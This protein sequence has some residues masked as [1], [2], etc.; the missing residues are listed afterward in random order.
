MDEPGGPDPEWEAYLAWL[1]REIAAGRAAEPPAPWQVEGP[2][3]S[4]SLGEAAGLDPA[5]LAAICGPD[6]LGGDA[7]GPEFAQGRVADA[8]RPGPVL[9]AL[10]E[11][12]VSD[13][14]ALTD[15]QLFG[16]LHAARRLENRIFYLQ[17]LAIAEFGRR[18]AAQRA[19]ADARGIVPGRRP[20]ERP[21]AELAAE[22]LISRHFAGDWLASA[23]DLVARLPRTLAGMA[24]GLIDPCRA[25]LIACY[26]ASL[27]LADAAAADEIL[28]AMAPEVT[29][30]TLARR[31][32]ALEIKLDPEAA[33][34]RRERARKDRQ[35]VEVR[36]EASG[37]ACVA[38][39]ELAV[40]QALASKANIHALALR[41]RRDGMPG[42]LDALRVTVFN[43]L[44][45]GRNP[46]D[47]AAAL[48]RQP[49][50][51]ATHD[52]G[53]HDDAARDDGTRA[54]GQ[55]SA[56]GSL[57]AD[58]WDPADIPPPEAPAD[59]QENPDPDEDWEVRAP[60]GGASSGWDRPGTAGS[61]WDLDYKDIRE[62]ED[63]EDTAARPHGSGA[64]PGGSAPPGSGGVASA[65]AVAPMPAVINLIVPAGTLLGWDN[66]PG[67]AA[68]WGLLDPSDTRTLVQASS[69]HPQTRWCLTL[70][71]ADGTA[72]AHG[73]SAGQHPWDPGG[74][75]WDPGGTPG[76]AGTT[77][78]GG[79]ADGRR[80]AGLVQ[81]ASLLRRLDITLEPIARGGCDHAS[82]EDRYTPSRKL[83]HLVRARTAT[84]TGPG[85]NAQ[86][87]YADLDHTVPW[88][89]GPTDQCNLGPKCRTHHRCKESP[90]WKLEQ[91]EPGVFRWTLPNGRVHTTRPTVYGIYGS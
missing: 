19:D 59:D 23:A 14:P 32:A 24:D 17:T 26:T 69:R 10:T 57:S 41:L 46:L 29:A 1:E 85:C 15:N 61:R 75:P 79:T 68:G 63:D 91:P 3:V 2:A 5:L 81:L 72:I 42:T 18:R 48:R 34:S 20:G 64:G 22:L 53:V 40:D 55:S 49:R 33:R 16:A 28:A 56:A 12:A 45:Q 50:A 74:H 77:G 30:E 82:A 58:D 36:R 60:A 89:I 78:H 66:T 39:R 37:N 71:A 84:C 8:L 6:G 65:P 87:C 44:L 4:I 27:S 7:L 54:G 76:H 62:E 86:A 38:G 88:P 51:A 25:G 47:R 13:L 70:T 31:A 83:K 67:Q 43:D 80:T 90:D 52:G 21:D 73:C 9:A 35:R 11:Q